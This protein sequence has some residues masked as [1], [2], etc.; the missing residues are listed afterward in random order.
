MTIALPRRDYA[1]LSV[2]DLLDAREAYHT[3]LLHLDNVVA[4]AIG[5]YRF[6]RTDAPEPEAPLAERGRDDP[7]TLANSEMRPYSW[8]CVLVFVDSWIPRAEFGKRVD[9]IVPPRLYLPDGRVVPTCVILAEKQ[10]ERVGELA[11]LRFPQTLLGGGY[12]SLADVQGQTRVATVGCLVSDGDSLYALTNAH[13][14]G[15]SGRELFTLVR[16]RRELLG[17]TANGKQVTKLPFSAAYPGFESKRT[18]LNLDAAL[19]RVEDATRWTSQIYGIGQFDELADLNVDTVSLDLIGCG[20]VAF[21]AASGE[22]R[23]EIQGLF[24]RYRSV[25]GQDQIADLLIGPRVAH[26]AVPKDASPE[27]RAEALRAQGAMARQLGRHGNSGAIWLLEQPPAR[28]GA[29]M[30]R[31]PIALH[32]GGQSF[33]TGAAQEATQYA[34][35]ASLGV[36]C[37]ELD[38]DLVRD[39][40]IGLPERWGKVG[41][42]KV[43]QLACEIPTAKDLATLLAKNKGRISYEED[44]DK[45]VASPTQDDDFIPLADVSD[46]VWKRGGQSVRGNESPNHFAD[47]DQVSLEL[48]GNLLELSADDAFLDPVRWNEFY[49][50]IDVDTSHRGL[51]PFRVWQIFDAMVDALENDSLSG[52][53]G[54]AGVLAHYVGDAC[55]P[56]H[57]SMLHDGDA[58][59]FGKGIHSAYETKMLDRFAP[60]LNVLVDGILVRDKPEA[61][62]IETGRAA[63]RALVALMTRSIQAIPPRELLEVYEEKDHKVK[64]LWDAFGERTAERIADGAT[65]LASL[66]RG[67]WK[68]ADA[69]GRFKDGQLRGV[70]RTRLR[71]LYLDKAWLPS[72]T[73]NKMRIV[74]E[75]IHIDA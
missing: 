58:N 41:H 68:A 30:R 23:G 45:E 73:I 8:P 25:G 51:L 2:K 64:E 57:V 50:S 72:T 3:H 17:R 38:V 63:A 24:Y 54:A 29:P 48:G 49:E 15:E 44:I 6:V 40:N 39:V 56:L 74:D 28:P 1:S 18:V 32:W 33:V 62:P 16:G 60:D 59:G 70:S 43:G 35:A 34:L 36:I 20:L 12:P 46:L 9:D 21:G 5:R 14:A 71:E 22:M 67:A 13:V 42:Y 52:F 53:I 47:M 65:V 10:P 31:R 19:V 26:P 4:T 75:R 55:Q 69:E 61:T 7:R 27:A 66:W 37:R 11:T